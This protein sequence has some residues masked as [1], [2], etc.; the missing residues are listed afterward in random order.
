M[1]NTNCLQFV[2]IVLVFN[3]VKDRRK[4]CS[5]LHGSEPKVPCQK[6]GKIE[7]GFSTNPLT[8]WGINYFCLI[9]FYNLRGS[10]VPHFSWKTII[11]G[12]VQRV[13]VSHQHWKPFQC[14]IQKVLSCKNLQILLMKFDRISQVLY[15]SVIGFFLFGRLQYSN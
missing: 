12:R 9:L 14:P 8:N 6:V 3:G 10:T 13:W 5:R 11:T 7:L 2:K 4:K 1:W 15:W